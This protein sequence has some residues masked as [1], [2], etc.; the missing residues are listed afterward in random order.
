MPTTR[1]QYFLFVKILVASA[2][3]VLLTKLVVTNAGGWSYLLFTLAALGTLSIACDGYTSLSQ[4]RLHRHRQEPETTGS[5]ATRSSRGTGRPSPRIIKLRF[6]DS[7][8]CSAS[9]LG[10]NAAWNCRCK[11]ATPMLGSL[12]IGREVQCDCCKRPF[13]VL[14]DSEGKRANAVEELP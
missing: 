1:S 8:E 7:T 2:C 6:Q 5:G 12:H 10:N 9:A 14:A 3:G 13:K 4:S 11:R